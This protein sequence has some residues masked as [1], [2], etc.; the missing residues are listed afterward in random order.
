MLGITAA[1]A[2]ALKVIEKRLPEVAYRALLILGVLVPIVATFYAMWRLPRDWVG[3]REIGLFLGL[4]LATGLGTTVGYHR[5]LTHRSFETTSSVR[6]VFLALGAMA[7][8][9]R[10]INWAAFHLAHHAHSDAEGDPHS[11]LDGFFHAHVGWILGR[12]AGRPGALLQTPA[13]GSAGGLRRQ[14]HRALGRPR[15]RHSLRSRRVDR[16]A[17]GR[18]GADRLHEPRD[19]RRQLRVPHFGSRPFATDDESRNNW[20]VGVLAFGEGW[21]NNHH[22]FPSMAFHGMSLRQPDLTGWVIRMLV[23]LRLAWSRPRAVRG[24]DRAQPAPAHGRFGGIR[25]GGP[26]IPGLRSARAEALDAPVESSRAFLE[27][28]FVDYGPRDFAVRFWDGS[29]LGR[30]HGVATLHA[31]AQA[32]GRAARDVLAAERALGR[33]GLSPRRLRHRRRH[34]GVPPGRRLPA[35]RSTIR[36]PGPA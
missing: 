12:S 24:P 14:D 28:L 3:P 17:V 11:P 5:L 4:Y 22:A 1:I 33:R 30:G 19:L 7:L 16:I 36:P 15:P 8:Q 23:R 35:D 34:R 2:I 21:H 18:A 9:G 10:P 26:A 31:R 27:S 32:S 20:I 6:F 13:Q 29:A 25:R